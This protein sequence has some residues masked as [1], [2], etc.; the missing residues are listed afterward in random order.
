[1][2][3]VIFV[4]KMALITHLLIDLAIHGEDDHWTKKMFRMTL[5][6]FYVFP[7]TN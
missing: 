1:M 7:T 2:D 5:K 3:D 4:P 6:V